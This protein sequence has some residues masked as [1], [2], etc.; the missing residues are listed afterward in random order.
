MNELIL[1]SSAIPSI[2]NPFFLLC[3]SKLGFGM[4]EKFG[5]KVKRNPENKFQCSIPK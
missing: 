3:Y 4:E 5:D 1:F 2:Q